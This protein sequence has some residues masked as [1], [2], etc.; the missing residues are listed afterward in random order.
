[1][2]FGLNQSSVTL[3]ALHI[4]QSYTGKIGLNDA[5][6]TVDA[7]TSEDN[8][9]EYRNTYLCISA[10]NIEIGQH[11]GSSTPVGSGRIKLNTG[12][13]QT[14]LNIHNTAT[15][16][17]DTHQQPVRW[18]GTHASNLIR[19]FRGKLGLASNL[20][21]ETATVDKLYVGQAGSLG[22]D[23]N[24]VIGQGATLTDL[25]QSGGSVT[26]SCNVVN[27]QQTA[28]KLTTQGTLSLTNVTIAGQADLMHVGDITNLIVG[29]DG[30]VDL[31]HQAAS[32]VITHC[33][34]YDGSTL[35]LN[36]GNPLSISFTNGID[37][38]ESLPQNVTI[39]W[40]PN[41]RLNVMAIS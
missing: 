6:F 19:I 12:T 3:S 33:N 2:L 18:V 20:P 34:V 7:D 14:T 17:A 35:N 24:V 11:A 37:C 10:T 13:A 28:G 23:A 9:Y 41:I 25:Y 21:G 39:N 29:H 27:L 5:V 1:V 15:S 16:S 32:R 26:V 4:K 40:W 8:Q 22:G 31:S 36:N 30:Q 38:I